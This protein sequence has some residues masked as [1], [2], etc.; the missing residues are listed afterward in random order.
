MYYHKLLRHIR[1]L[2]LSLTLRLSA[3]DN[4]DRVDLIIYTQTYTAILMYDMH[5]DVTGDRSARNPRD[6]FSVVGLRLLFA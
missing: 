1:P 4:V 2:F 6:G 5:E 3:N